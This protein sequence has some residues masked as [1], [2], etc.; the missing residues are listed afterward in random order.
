MVRE[1]SL[2]HLTLLMC[3]PPSL[4]EI[5]ARTGYDYVSLRPIA[6]TADEPRYAF[7]E[8]KALR[9]A[10]KK[11]LAD[12]G[13]RLLDIELARIADDI[14]PK[15]YLPAFEAAAELGGKYVLS[16]VWT[17]DRARAVDRFAEL[18]RLA[19]PFDLAV[20]LEPVSFSRVKTLAEAA[21]IV[22]AT[23]AANGAICIDT[24]H[25]DRAGD[26]AEDIDALPASLFPFM[27]LCD[28]ISNPTATLEENIFTARADRKFC[29]EGDLPLADIVGHLPAIPCSL[30]IPN[31]A[32]A[33]SMAPIDYARRC[34]DTAR[35]YLEGN[36]RSKSRR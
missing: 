4:I 14:E 35:A 33:L 2:A 19:K 23:R 22:T 6:V 29:G 10:T 9:Q 13:M 12:T 30:E 21:A 25:F 27:Q 7:G 31:A 28:A 15:S 18:C 1:F 11:R 8:D 17:Q 36:S 26:R 24:L 5:A 34:L 16:S 20:S 32:A 3:D